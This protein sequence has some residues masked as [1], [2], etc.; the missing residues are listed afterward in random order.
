MTDRNTPHTNELLSAF[1]TEL[2]TYINA[3]VREQTSV[4]LG[5]IEQLQKEIEQL[6]A[7]PALATAEL[8][9]EAL[10]A[11]WAYVQKP[12]ISETKVI[13]LSNREE[14][15]VNFLF[16]LDRKI[17]DRR[18]TSKLAGPIALHVLTVMENPEWQLSNYNHVVKLSKIDDSVSTFGADPGALLPVLDDI[19]SLSHCSFERKKVKAGMTAHQ[20]K[21]ANEKAEKAAKK[22]ENDDKRAGAD[23]NPK[24]KT[25]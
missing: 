17:A 23:A 9:D 15:Y 14:E 25:K 3:R 10:K 7:N 2:D 19:S 4:Y 22:K 11:I 20:N 12:G 24:P 5:Q 8:Q 13:P 18:I 6:R 21:L 1:A 16:E